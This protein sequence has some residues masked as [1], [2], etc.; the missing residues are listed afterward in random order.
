M[1]QRVKEKRGKNRKFGKIGENMGGRNREGKPS[2]LIR[3]GVLA[4]DAP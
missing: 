3:R 4:V 2:R 1:Q